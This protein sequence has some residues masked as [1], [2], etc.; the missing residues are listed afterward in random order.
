MAIKTTRTIL[1]EINVDVT[2][3]QESCVNK[4]AE[5]NIYNI[6]SLPISKVRMQMMDM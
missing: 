1:T 5:I 4:H 2:N 6:V 3:T